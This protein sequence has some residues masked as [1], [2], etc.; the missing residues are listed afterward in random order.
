M[1]TT[2][3][4]NRTD[5][6][7]TQTSDCA[8]FTDAK[9][10]ISAYHELTDSI[11]GRISSVN[12]ISNKTNLLAINATI[13]VIHASDLLASFEKI[14]EENLVIQAKLF[15][16]ILE[17]DPDFLSWDGKTLAA[18]CSIEEYYI[19]DGDGAILQTNMPVQKGAILRTQALKHLL[20]D[21][22]ALTVLPTTANAAGSEHYK[23]IGLGRTDAPGLIQLGIHFKK[24]E[25]QV[26]INGFGVVA[27]EAK[28][29]ADHSREVSAEISMMTKEMTAQI[30]L[31]QELSDQAERCEE[32]QTS[33]FSTHLDDLRKSFRGI[34]SHLTNLISLARQT[35]L[36]GVRA[37][38]E[39]AHSTN[40]KQ[41]FDQLL[42]LHMTTEA[43]LSS[44]LVERLPSL[45]CEELRDIAADC[46]LAEI[47]VSDE[48]GVVE[49]TNIVEAKGFAYQNE[50]QTA[51]Y[52]A[53]L[54]NPNL[55][56]TAPPSVRALDHCVF[57]YV[58][59]GRRG[60]P[61][62]FQVGNPSKLYGDSTSKGFFEVS[63]S[64]KNL[65]EQSRLITGEIQ[66]IVEQ[67]DVY[68]RKALDILHNSRR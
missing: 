39:A 58:G 23:V 20:G 67:M 3:D 28:R 6:S 14:V 12:D 61:G 15:A 8:A 48:R 21:P 50:G 52:M 44:I 18:D 16:K 64:I 22:G 57:K 41:E 46:G 10:A 35:S 42:D 36:L 55:I 1:E 63:K 30:T 9:A 32:D 26:A 59:I 54:T 5:S 53:L 13:E 38:I 37:S 4:R 11:L 2:F 62:I 24:P 29:L 34:L 49:L 7:P 43:K 40:E 27:K 51:P 19:T 66:E 60:K 56:V 45:T 17:S 68:A 31:V 25:G 65:A 47:W 33:Q